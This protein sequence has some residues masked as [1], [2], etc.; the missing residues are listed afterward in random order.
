[1]TDLAALS[2]KEAA[3]KALEGFARVWH[4]EYYSEMSFEEFLESNDWPTDPAELDSHDRFWNY[5]KYEADKKKDYTFDGLTSKLVAE[6][7]G[8]GQGDEYWVVISVSDGKTTR[9]FRKDGHYASYYGGELDGY[10]AEVQP[11]EKVITVYN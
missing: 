6:Y 2:T 9:Y 3:S 8:E 11:K 10:T 5:L 7:G 4:D 1:M